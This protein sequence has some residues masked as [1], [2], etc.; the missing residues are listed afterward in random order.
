MSN[1]ELNVYYLLRIA[2]NMSI[3]ELADELQVTTS[4]IS[5]IEK[6]KRIPSKR[7]IRDYARVLNVDEQVL[8]TFETSKGPLNVFEKSLLKLLEIICNIKE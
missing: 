5:A 3:K 2:R 4:Y 1:K 6:G 8:K 7:L